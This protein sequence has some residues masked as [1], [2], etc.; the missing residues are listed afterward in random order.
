MR[1]PY[2]MVKLSLPL[3]GKDGVDTVRPFCTMM[4]RSV[5]RS[6]VERLLTQHRP[7]L[8]CQHNNKHVKRLN[9][10]SSAFLSSL[11]Q[12]LVATP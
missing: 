3:P 2:A 5:R 8:C 1:E 10:K 11:K 9:E 7:S 4:P 6:P 12:Q